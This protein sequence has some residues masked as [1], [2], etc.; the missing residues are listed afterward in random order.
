MT[1]LVFRARAIGYRVRRKLSKNYNDHNDPFFDDFCGACGLASAMIAFELQRPDSLVEGT[2]LKH[3]HNKLLRRETHCWVELDGY[4]VD[5]TATQFGWYAAVHIEPVI[6]SINYVA[7]KRGIQA[8]NSV[9]RWYDD[10]EDDIAFFRRFT[11]QIKE[12]CG[13]QESLCM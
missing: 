4:I 13:T 8:V 1:E 3:Q 9:R 2:F 7:D 5:A 12:G 10:H 11:R 6:E